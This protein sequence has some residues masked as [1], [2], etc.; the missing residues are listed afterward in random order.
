M[1]DQQLYSIREAE[2]AAFC[3]S[4]SVVVHSKDADGWRKLY[5][6]FDE[7]TS[8]PYIGAGGHASVPVRL[9][10]IQY[11][12]NLP[13]LSP[14][15][16]PAWEAP[17]LRWIVRHFVLAAS[18]LHFAGSW[19]KFAQWFSINLSDEVHAKG[20]PELE[21][22]E[23]LM[24]RFFEPTGTFPESL[25]VLQMHESAFE[26]YVSVSEL[27]EILAVEDRVGL[28]QRLAGEYSASEDPIDQGL[29]AEIGGLYHFLRLVHTQHRAVYYSQFVT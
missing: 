7:T 15:E 24:S 9:T 1:S 8:K 21:E 11:Q 4:V 6:A 12:T 20:G 28:L 5:R 17:S 23:L 16:L 3:K 22:H 19:G 26:S 27:K 18:D 2:V 25:R 29:G 10:R 14:D 13:D